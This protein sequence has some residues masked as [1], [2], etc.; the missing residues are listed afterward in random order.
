MKDILKKAIILG[1]SFVLAIVLVKPIGVSTEY[2]VGAGI[3]D[4]TI[5]GNNINREYYQKDNGKIAEEIQN[6]INYN[7][8]FVLAIPFGGLIAKIIIDRKN[9]TNAVAVKHNTSSYI[10]L[11]IGGFLLLFGAR[12]AGGC[13]SG[14]MMSGIMQT[15]ISGMVFAG[16][17]FAVAIGLSLIG[18]RK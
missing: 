12:L 15:S 6:P 4:T 13:T 14:H 10:K 7:N 2:S 8:I 1:L 5:D 17:V 16:V 11:F 3:V 18:R 9:K